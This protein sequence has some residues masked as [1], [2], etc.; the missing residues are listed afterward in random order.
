MY[1]LQSM[2]AGM[3]AIRKNRSISSV[4]NIQLITLVESPP[5][6]KEDILN[7]TETKQLVTGQ[8]HPA[9]MIENQVSSQNFIFSLS[10]GLKYKWIHERSHISTEKDMKTWLIIAVIHTTLSTCEIKAGIRSHD[11]R[12]TG[13][14]LHQPSHQANWELFT[15]WSLVFTC[16]LHTVGDVVPGVVV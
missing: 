10:Q 4:H 8:R 11:L 1:F 13:A 16:I 5:I 7:I 2:K 14:A 3:K 9:V 6:L 15:L 12:D